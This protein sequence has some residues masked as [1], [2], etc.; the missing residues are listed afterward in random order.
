MYK[1]ILV[2]LFWGAFFFFYSCVDH[3][4]DLVNKEISTDVKLEGNKIAL[5]IGSLKAFV[6]DSL[7]DTEGIDLLAK[8]EDG[9]YSIS[10]KDDI[11]ITESIDPIKLSIDPI[12]ES[13][14]MSFNDAKITDV[15]I[16]GKNIDPAEFNTPSISFSDLNSKLPTLKSNVSQSVANSYLDQIFD[17]ID[18][19][20]F[21]PA[22]LGKIPFN[23]TIDIE[24]QNVDCSFE[25]KLPNEIE[26][27]KKIKLGCKVEVIVT[28]PLALK[29]I[30]KSIDFEIT[31]PEMF[32]LSLDNDA[33]QKSKYS[34][35]NKNTIKVENLIPEANSN[36]TPISFYIEEISNVESL[37][38]NGT[39]KV[40]E[41]IF[42][43][44]N[45][46]VEGDI[47]PDAEIMKRENFQFNVFI[48]VPLQF[49]DIQGKTKDLQVDFKPIDIE[50]SGE[51]DNLKHIDRIDYI[52]FNAEKSHIKFETKMEGN[53]F[54]DFNL[55]NG[56]A[57]KMDFPDSLYIDNELSSYE[58]KGKEI[59]YDE[60][61]HA[62]YIYDISI[63][64][65]THWDIALH[66]FSLYKEIDKTDENNYTCKMDVKANIS[67]IDSDKNEIEYLILAGSEFESMAAT[68]ENLKGNKKAEFTMHGA[69][70]VIKDAVVQTEV[71]QASTNTT[72]KFDILEEVPSEIGR[73]DSIGFTK[74]VRMKFDLE[75]LGLDDLNTDIE[76]DMNLELPSFLK[77]KKSPNS[78]P[79]VAITIGDGSLNIN[80]LYHPSSDGKL[81]FELICDGLDFVKEFGD[82]ALTPA[83]STD[84]NK[85]LK[86]SNNISVNG[87]ASIRGMEF[88]STVLDKLDK[89]EMFVNFN[90]DDIE[91]KTF[92]GIY[93]GKIDNI[94]ESFDL[95]LGDELAF[96]KEEGN[97]I[98]L[99]EPQLEFVIENTIGIPVDVN[100]ELFCKD[101]NGIKIPTSE[102][103][104]QLSI[105]PAEY[106]AKTGEITAKETKIFIT[107]DASR[108]SKAGYNN[109]EIPNLANL[110]AKVPNSIDFK[111][112][113]VIKGGSH[114]VNIADPIKLNGSY[115]VV[116][117]LKF[118]NFSMCYSDTI[119]GLKGSIEETLDMVS[120]ISLTAKMDIINTIPL[121]LSL[122]VVP[123]DEN[124]KVIEDITIDEL[125]IK[126]G[127]GG[128]II[129]E[130]GKLS[131]Q[132]AQN[133]V[134]S[135]KSKKGDISALDKLA[136]S[137]KAATDHTTGTSGLKGTQG[138]KISNIV[139][140]VGGD[141][142][143][144]L[145]E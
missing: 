95:D 30:D 128:C 44:I 8:G 67:F 4:Y 9:V 82:I 105:L 130:N 45:Y 14:E 16:E 131:E 65:N 116:I 15:H 68:L 139:F 12:Q 99:A 96:L 3:N 93:N 76:L 102:I 125:V 108:V 111:I 109:V 38:N 17:L 61:A 101:E 90:I 114:H 52:L 145:N 46:S 141:I 63:L 89:I 142:A 40:D 88:H 122:K 10:K 43:T 129:D 81:E 86:Y 113:P 77:L 104:T 57:L 50:F 137:I 117:P 47:V 97:S 120:N 2:V 64:A 31:F 134:F 79:D 133:F 71:I 13:M 118:D 70:L 73:I 25:Y 100:L 98:T 24:N 21:N 27:I 124:N 83:D 39:I 26:T 80:T 123:L 66:K 72:S 36:S 29:N 53:W 6:L 20:T 84:G 37:I 41:E 42:Y 94:E 103:N 91:V 1:K 127:E 58:G 18:K 56:Y 32:V 59:V 60:E 132:E 5:P 143:I 126:A 110:L 138:I 115:A 144:D 54:N 48:N 75:I 7:I 85:Y 112:E 119:G 135:I 55:K 35:L 92:H 87:D 106:N 107:S 136:F 51:F 74:D 62:F 34:L 19:G 69:D 78:N 11:S 49:E 33:S 140:E 28:H 22:T 23:Q 121:G